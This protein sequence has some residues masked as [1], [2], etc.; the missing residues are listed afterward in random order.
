MSYYCEVTGPDGQEYEYF[1]KFNPDKRPGD[2]GSEEYALFHGWEVGTHA[3]DSGWTGRKRLLRTSIDPF[4][5]SFNV[6]SECGV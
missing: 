5:D 2:F 6:V 1:A 3:A 4:P